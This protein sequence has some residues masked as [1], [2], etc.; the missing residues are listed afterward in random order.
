VEIG[1]ATA[2][3]PQ[4]VLLDEPFSG[5]NPAES[6]ALSRTLARISETRGIA[7]VLVEHDVEVVFEL[8]QRIYVLD[9][10]Q[11]IAEGTAAEI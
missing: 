2:T 7:M 11:L 3:R 8:S 9:F 5:L 1:R 6:H 10:G 4:V